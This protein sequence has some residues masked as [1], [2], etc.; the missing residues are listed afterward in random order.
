MGSSTNE[1]FGQHVLQI[2]DSLGVPAISHT[3]VCPQSAQRGH[4]TEEGREV[5][6][7]YHQLGQIKQPGVIIF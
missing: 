4:F 1:L 6:E 5:W 7:Q 3:G 2:I